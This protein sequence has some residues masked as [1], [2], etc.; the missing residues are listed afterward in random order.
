[1]DR[2]ADEIDRV[3]L[4]TGFCGVVRVDRRG[5]V[6]TAKAFGLAHRGHRIPNAVD[7]R[8][9]IASGTKGLTALTVMSLMA[10]GPSGRTR[11]HG[12]CSDRTCHSSTTG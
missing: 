10:E 9:G 8:F 7:T 12:R 5:A 1:M 4:A 6:R 11:P 3:A 2:L